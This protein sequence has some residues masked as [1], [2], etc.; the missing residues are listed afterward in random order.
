[1]ASSVGGNNQQRFSNSHFADPELFALLST[2][3]GGEGY[4]YDSNLP[5]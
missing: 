5:N 3:P 1:M 4:S 2:A